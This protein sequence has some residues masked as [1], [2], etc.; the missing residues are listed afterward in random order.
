[1]EQ[2]KRA[3]KLSLMFGLP[4]AAAVPVAFEIYANVSQWFALVLL[5]GW[6]TFVGIRFYPLETKPAFVGIAAFIAYTVAFGIV[7]HAPIHNAVKGWLEENSEYFQLDLK[8]AGFFWLTAVLLYFLL[9]L[10]A[11]LRV[12]VKRIRANS[13]RTERYIDRAFDDEDGD[14]FGS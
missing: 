14:G 1:M 2:M 13:E 7:L 3:M 6:I 5:G 8:Q 12:A 11:I 10:S 9:F 4:G